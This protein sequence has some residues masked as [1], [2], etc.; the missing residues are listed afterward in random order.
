MERQI[1]EQGHKKIETV[2]TKN[3]PQKNNPSINED[4]QKKEKQIIKEEKSEKTEEK[5]ETKE[6]K[7]QESPGIKKDYAV[8]YGKD[9]PI[10]YKTS[11]AI[12]RFIK[13]KNPKKAL[14]MLNLVVEKKISIPVRGESPHRKDLKHGFARGKYPKK[15]SKYFIK[16]LKSLIANAKNN[17]LDIEKTIITIAK[18][19]KASNPVRGTRMG[20]GR[21]KFKRAHIFIRAEEKKEK[22]NSEKTKQ[23]LN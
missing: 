19:D 18:A 8:V 5:K 1:A 15:S 9:L 23:T 3:K 13:N 21:K 7:K 17:G 12:G 22:I 16:L 4:I 2:L 14:D 11:G 6:L 20:F 10:S